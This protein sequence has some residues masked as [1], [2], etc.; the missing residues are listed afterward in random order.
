MEEDAAPAE[1]VRTSP[2][3]VTWD[4]PVASEAV[5]PADV[6]E[7]VHPVGESRPV[8]A[9]NQA[10]DRRA[11]QAPKARHYDR[12][13]I[14]TYMAKQKRERKEKHTVDVP[15]TYVCNHS[16]PADKHR[17]EGL[18]E[19]ARVKKVQRT[20]SRDR[21]SDAPPTLDWTRAQPTQ[22]T[23]EENWGPS[24]NFARTFLV[25]PEPI[26]PP[27]AVPIREK[28][29]QTDTQ[30][31][32]APSVAS[33]VDEA[34]QVSPLPSNAN[35]S[36]ASTWLHVHPSRLA[37]APEASIEN[38]LIGS[39]SVSISSS[40]LSSHV[41]VDRRPSDPSAVVPDDHLIRQIEHLENYIGHL[42]DA[43]PF[44]T[45]VPPFHP[46]AL[47]A[48]N[49]TSF[50]HIP[51]VE[52]PEDTPDRPPHDSVSRQKHDWT[53]STQYHQLP[54]RL[55][56]FLKL[57]KPS[58]NTSGNQA[59]KDIRQTD[60]KYQH[61]F[62]QPEHPKA[63]KPKTETEVT[64]IFNMNRNPDLQTPW[65]E[66]AAGIGSE[67]PQTYFRDFNEILQMD[68]KTNPLTESSLSWKRIDL[69]RSTHNRSSFKPDVAPPQ[70]PPYNILTAISGRLAQG[71]QQIPLQN[72]TSDSDFRSGI[73]MSDASVAD[74]SDAATVQPKADPKN[75]LGT[76][77]VNVGADAG[78]S[79][80]NLSGFNS[81]AN[82]AGSSRKRVPSPPVRHPVIAVQSPT[83]AKKSEAGTSQ[84]L[85]L[86]PPQLRAD[87]SR[88]EIS[89][90]NETT[91]RTLTPQYTSFDST[92]EIADEAP[93]E[94][95]NFDETS[96]RPIFPMN[97]KLSPIPRPDSS[98]AHRSVSSDSE[99]NLSLSSSGV[100]VK[101]KQSTSS[102]R[103]ERD[104]SVG[105][106]PVVVV[107][108]NESKTKPATNETVDSSKPA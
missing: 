26:P 69:S 14:R 76:R 107:S 91:Y 7:H 106:N 46:V 57:K 74:Q 31:E 92:R 35:E 64:S 21:A 98:I 88:L 81:S 20:K 5:L 12:R 108:R 2:P 100:S 65:T 45:Y 70:Q 47:P 84:S 44:R 90:L 60:Y 43:P 101:R 29:I 48:D 104:R 72:T 83:P 105:E 52:Q 96:F 13:E 103:S 3:V 63:S 33:K 53:V 23:E 37:T 85:D 40:T 94:T 51:P 93:A 11:A 1:E 67:E 89:G 34:I 71:I 82:S 87:L 17:M 55:N 77:I 4:I 66:K 95:E 15:A 30:V 9:S 22:K 97:L 99:P 73:S 16:R 50:H 78:D 24:A 10:D 62:R 27:R 6:S 25:P 19:A 38:L 59:E 68:C 79:S 8:A 61:F 102:E 75:G 41:Q 28:S 80:I 56:Q 18:P 39:A 58:P 42:L 54:D 86:H 36:T 49:S 32:Q